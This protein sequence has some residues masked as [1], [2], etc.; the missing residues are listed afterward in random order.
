[1][2]RFQAPRPDKLVTSLADAIQAVMIPDQANA[3]LRPV[4]DTL[5]STPLQTMQTCDNRDTLV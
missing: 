3:A 4:P 1:M 2:E 5:L